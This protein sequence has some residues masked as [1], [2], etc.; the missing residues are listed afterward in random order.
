MEYSCAPESLLIP[1]NSNILFQLATLYQ[2]K[3]P[4]L[5]D[6]HPM[7][8]P[9]RFRLFPLSNLQISRRASD[10]LIPWQISWAKPCSDGGWARQLLSSSARVL[11]FKAE[12]GNRWKRW[13]MALR[14]H[15]KL[16]EFQ[17]HSIIYEKSLAKLR[18]TSRRWLSTQNAC[19]QLTVPRSSLCNRDE[20]RRRQPHTSTLL[21]WRATLGPVHWVE[22]CRT[23]CEC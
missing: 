5:A 13:G 9:T 15:T 8:P 7:P 10:W 14:W 2:P 11:S 6:A 23:G 20:R 1:P 12:C 18:K 22:C 21:A 19:T 16:A 4:L 3:V 17:R